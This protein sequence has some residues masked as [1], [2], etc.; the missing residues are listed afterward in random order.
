M[1]CTPT[2]HDAIKADPAEFQQHPFIGYTRDGTVI[3]EVRTCRRCCSSIARD[4]PTV[5]ITRVLFEGKHVMRRL[6]DMAGLAYEVDVDTSRRVDLAIAR[7]YM[8]QAME[9][10]RKH[11]PKE[12]Q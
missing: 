3:L 6:H 7:G 10:F 9:L 4:V 11:L 8:R 12:L 2:E 1:V 5:D